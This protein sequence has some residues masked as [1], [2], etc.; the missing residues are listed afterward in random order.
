MR[1]SK[2]GTPLKSGYLSTVGLSI[3]HNKAGMLF[4]GINIDDFEP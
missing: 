1:V 3:Y 4:N 2:R